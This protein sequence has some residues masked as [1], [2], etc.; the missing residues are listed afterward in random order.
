MNIILCEPPLASFVCVYMCA[1][2]PQKRTINYIFRFFT[3]DNSVKGFR[4]FR[5]NYAQENN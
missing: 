2:I 4:R 1:V 5:A 3:S